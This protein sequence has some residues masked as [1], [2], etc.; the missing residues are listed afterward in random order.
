MQSIKGSRTEANL[1]EAFA[2]E[3]MARNKYDFYAARA[4]KEGYEQIAE[5]LGNT[6]NNEREH[7]KIWFKLLH[8]D[9]RDTQVNLTDA[10][11]GEN[12]EWSEM[13]VRFA[14]EATKEGFDEIARLFAAVAEIEKSH[15]QKFLQCLSDLQNG[16]VFARDRQTVW[17]CRNC[18]HL[19]TDKEA[20]EVC[21]VCAHPQSFFM[22]E[23]KNCR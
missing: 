7:A 15:E 19:H 3:C 9:W 18:G 16:E 12:Y 4:K 17:V 23:C 21:P 5:I 13:Y 20:P 1:L 14:D 8:G 2:G 22:P 10:A 6:A 11:N